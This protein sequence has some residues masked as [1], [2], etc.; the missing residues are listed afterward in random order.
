MNYTDASIAVLCESPDILPSTGRD[1][2]ILGCTN[3][4]LAGELYSPQKIELVYL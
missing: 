4:T 1:I 3:T 2:E